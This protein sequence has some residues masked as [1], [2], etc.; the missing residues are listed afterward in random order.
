VIAE[1]ER[2]VIEAEQDDRKK[3][4]SYSIIFP[5]RQTKIRKR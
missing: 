5:L 2:G 4:R 1:G 3:E